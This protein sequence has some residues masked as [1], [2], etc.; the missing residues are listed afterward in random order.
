MRKPGVSRGTRN[1]VV[2]CLSGTFGSVRA[3]MKNS[4]PT[5]ALA[6]RHFSPLRI[7]SSPWRSA[8]SLR[9]A[10]GSSGGS[11]LS[12]PALGSLMPLP[13]RKVSSSRNG[14]RK[15]RF[16]SSLQ[17]AAI[18]WLHFQ[19]WLKVLEIA[20]SPLAS[21]AITSAC[22]TKSRPCPPHSFGTASVRNPSLEPFLKSSQSKVSRGS[23]MR[24]RASETGRISSSANFRAFI[25]QARCSSFS[26][27]SILTSLSY[28]SQSPVPSRSPVAGERFGDAKLVV[29]VAVSGVKADECVVH[30]FLQRHVA[31]HTHGAEQLGG[32]LDGAVDRAGREHLRHHCQRQIRQAAVG[33]RLGV[34][35]RKRCSPDGRPRH[36][37]VDR[38]FREL[39]A[40]RLMLD[41]APP[42]LD[43]QRYVVERGLVS[44]S[45]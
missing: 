9:P 14:L 41:D 8:L 19:H 34:I 10:L 25:C 28:A 23:A 30:V 2:P 45:T 1:M 3:S 6:M 24:S 33:E 36:F 27:K 35:R 22:V 15:R 17:A 37:E 13:S 5:L 7:H 39:G 29:S 21:S 32:I 20:L 12:E 40:D 26:E 43:T 18:R 4:L 16:C 42:A 11:R 38:D 44:S 31:H